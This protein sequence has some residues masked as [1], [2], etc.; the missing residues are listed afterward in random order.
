MTT[1]AIF[2]IGAYYD[3]TRDMTDEFV[4]QG[5]AC[6]GWSVQ[7][8][9]ALHRIVGHIKVGDLIYIKSFNPRV[10]LKIKAVGIVVSTEVDIPPEQ[11]GQRGV[12]MDWVWRGSFLVG[13]IGD[14]YN[15]RGNTLFE[16]FNPQVQNLV[17]DALRGRNEIGARS[18]RLM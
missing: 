13:R 9:P 17:I 8:A 1:M 6:V 18:G 7:D 12:Q 4:D 11:L 15:V 3:G 16:E 14:K 5:W 10:G 2:G